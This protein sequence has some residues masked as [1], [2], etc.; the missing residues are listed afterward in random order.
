VAGDCFNAGFISK[1]IKRK[2]LEE[3][4]DFGVLLGAANTTAAGGTGAFKSLDAL[5]LTI[6]KKFNKKVDLS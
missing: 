1:Y 2:S 6:E 4:L 5:K 3:C